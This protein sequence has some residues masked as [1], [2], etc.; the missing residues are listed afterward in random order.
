MMRTLQKPFI[1]AKIHGMYSRF[2]SIDSFRTNLQNK[3]PALC[4][5]NLNIHPISPLSETSSQIQRET[6]LHE[7]FYRSI[8]KLIPEKGKIH[9]LFKALISEYELRNISTFIKSMNN[10][11][12]EKNIYYKTHPELSEFPEMILENNP[13]LSIRLLNE[14]S[15]SEILDNYRQNED[16]VEL[17]AMLEK[18]YFEKLNFAIRQLDNNDRAS[19]TNLYRI[20]LSIKNRINT[21]R[22]IK[23]YN[24]EFDDFLK[25]LFINDSDELSLRKLI[26]N[27]I[28]EPVKAFPRDL[29]ASVKNI[30]VSHP[31]L[32][33]QDF[34]SDIGYDEISLIEKISSILLH[35][36]FK[37]AF[38]RNHNTI[39]PFFCF[40]FLLKQEMQNINILL[41]CVRMSIKS[42]DFI[43]ELL[44]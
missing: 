25:W 30:L 24:L 16:S 15:Y 27:E 6:L 40:Y 17:D 18:V 4:L 31:H 11:S 3:T 22:F 8:I 23:L 41:N 43:N 36:F 42:E 33:P 14:S 9:S 32:N 12:E 19:I 44:I 29:S 38:Y 26:N 39:A 21:L 20:M 10:K 35:K 34:D 13:D 2:N 28:S 37:K 1:Y 7:S 5:N